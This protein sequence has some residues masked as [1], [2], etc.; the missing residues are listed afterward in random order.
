MRPRRLV[1]G[2][3]RTT[4]LIGAIVLL[5]ACAAAGSASSAPS[6]I[7]ARPSAP[8]ATRSA[9]SATPSRH[10]AARAASPVNPPPNPCARNRATH[11]VRV[12]LA[13][14]HL[15]MCARQTV[16]YGTPITSGVVGPYTSTPTGHF[17][18]QGVDRNTVLTLN[19]G[20]TYH[21]KYWIP[22]D[23]PLFGFHDSSW[24]K[25]PYGSPRYRTEGSHGC[26]HLPLG[27]IARLARWAPVGTPVTIA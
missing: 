21:V 24:Q 8:V 15:W 26:V 18:I 6:A 12:S 22:F 13:E 1:A 25:F 11:A 27:A 17:R 7:S 4:V 5:G 14:Q 10:V 20:A 2:T 16:A 9:P 3:V 19:T 23:A